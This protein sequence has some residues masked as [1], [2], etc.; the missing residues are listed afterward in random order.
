M[1]HEELTR[2]VIIEK[3]RTDSLRYIEE[4]SRI[5]LEYGKKMLGN[6]FIFQQDRGPPHRQE[7]TP[8]WCEKDFHDFWTKDR[9]PANIPELSPLDHCIQEE[10]RQ[11]MDWN[12]IM[13]KQTLMEQIKQGVKK[14]SN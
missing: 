13:N 3:G 11:Q 2:P 6:E 14:D 5:A 12:R 1:C 7:L 8:Q 9:W 10:I 4:I